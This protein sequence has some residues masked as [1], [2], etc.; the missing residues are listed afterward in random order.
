VKLRP[1]HL[2][3][4]AAGAAFIMAGL[5]QMASAP[6]DSPPPTEASPGT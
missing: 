2:L 1:V 4:L 3:A 6:V 5:W